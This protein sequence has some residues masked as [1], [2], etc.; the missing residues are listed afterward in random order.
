MHVLTNLTFNLPLSPIFLHDVIWDDLG[1]VLLT[2]HHR[3]SRRCEAVRLLAKHK[4]D[5]K[6]QFIPVRQFIL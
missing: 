2:K 6:D 1:R 4:K 5:K 3:Q